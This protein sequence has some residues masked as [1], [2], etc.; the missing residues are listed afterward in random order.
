[1]VHLFI[2]ENMSELLTLLPEMQDEIFKYCKISDLINLAC[3][4]SEWSEAL[5]QRLWKRIKI[6]STSLVKQ[7]SIFANKSKFKS[8]RHTRHLCFTAD[9]TVQNNPLRGNRAKK[10]CTK[11]Y[12][13]VLQL[14]GSFDG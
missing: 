14:S 11:N 1:M 12:S 7:F 3:C 9:D 6:P 2:S 13:K 10:K 4:S 5:K 8:L